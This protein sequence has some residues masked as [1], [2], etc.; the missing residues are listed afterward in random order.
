MGAS[1]AIDTTRAD[2]HWMTVSFC[3]KT[4]NLKQE[5]RQ[6]NAK[7]GSNPSAILLH[8]FPE[9]YQGAS[10]GG[11]GLAECRN[12]QRCGFRAFQ[13]TPNFM[14]ARP[15]APDEFIRADASRRHR[16]RKLPR[17]DAPECQNIL[18]PNALGLEK[19]IKGLAFQ[20]S[21]PA[22]VTYNA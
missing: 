8:G 3:A 16:F 21:H 1:V 10:H 22:T 13:K 9:R 2:R 6:H 19:L 17:D 14:R 18:F 20:G 15:D 12:Q 4:T 5:R 11:H 7:E